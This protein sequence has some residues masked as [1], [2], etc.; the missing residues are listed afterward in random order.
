MIPVALIGLALVGLFLGAFA[1]DVHE[2]WPCSRC[3][4]SSAHWCHFPCL[5]HGRECRYVNHH[6]YRTPVWPY[7]LLSA[8]MF[9]DAVAM[10]VVR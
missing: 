4:R 6:V 8:L 5:T 1:L 9:A 7:Y 2:S 3:G 10:L